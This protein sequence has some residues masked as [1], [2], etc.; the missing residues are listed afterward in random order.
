MLSKLPL[1]LIEKPSTKKST[2]ESGKEKADPS[3]HIPARPSYKAS[4]IAE[5][6]Q[7][8]EFKEL[9]EYICEIDGE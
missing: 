2:K 1:G 4:E 7:T 3:A 5:V 6:N 8:T 9:K